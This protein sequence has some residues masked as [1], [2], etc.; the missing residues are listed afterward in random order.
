M[1]ISSASLSS[2]TAFAFFLEAFLGALPLPLAALVNSRSPLASEA[3]LPPSS[4]EVSVGEPES[5]SD[6]WKSSSTKEVSQ[7]PEPM[8]QAIHVY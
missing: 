8:L 6:T 2:E 5:E 1:T 7:N 3:V 4:D